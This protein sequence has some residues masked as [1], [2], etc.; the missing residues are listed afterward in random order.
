MFINLPLDSMEIAYSK[1]ELEAG[2][3]TLAVSAW[4]TTEPG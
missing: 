4:T 1:G 2:P 3:A